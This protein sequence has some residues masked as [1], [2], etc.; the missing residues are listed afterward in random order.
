MSFFNISNAIKFSEWVFLLYM[1]RQH[2]LIQTSISSKY[3]PALCFLLSFPPVTLHNS[4][5]EDIQSWMSINSPATTCS[6]WPNNMS[7]RTK[8]GRKY[9]TMHLQCGFS[10]LWPS[11]RTELRILNKN[12]FKSWIDSAYC[13]FHS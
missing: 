10:Y 1:E 3:K 5:E 4:A 6:H 8:S 12:N 11:E 9:T 7:V 13:I 2:P